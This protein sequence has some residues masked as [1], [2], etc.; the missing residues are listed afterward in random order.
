MKSNRLLLALVLGAGLLFVG[1][2]SAAT[3]CLRRD[4]QHEAGDV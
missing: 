4:R 2:L 3:Q 1:G